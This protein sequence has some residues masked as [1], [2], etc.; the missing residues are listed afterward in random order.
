M[1]VLCRDISYTFP[2]VVR[3]NRGKLSRDGLLE[4]AIEFNA[5]KVIIIE[6]W[7]EGTG[8]M[9]FFEARQ[10]S[11][12][13]VPPIIYVR[14]ERLRRN[15]EVQMR[16]GKTIKS[17]AIV[18]SS[19]K[20]LDAEKLENMFAEFFGIPIVS[21]REAISG[22]YDAAMQILSNFLNHI[23]ITFRLIPEFVE[24]G[25]KLDVARLVWELK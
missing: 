3:I 5:N 21:R 19:K 12:V 20:M 11:L 6:R 15:F 7:S 16:K 9:V 23:T 14:C 8:K 18:A 24:I 1:R 22:N 13:N 4:R 2:S 10:D 25:P 17:I